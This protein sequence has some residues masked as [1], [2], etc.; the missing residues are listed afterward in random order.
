MD[1]AARNC[2]VGNDNT[3]KVFYHFLLLFMEIS[4]FFLLLAAGR[5]WL[6]WQWILV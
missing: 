6:G 4:F 5:L 2:L 3:V 1:I